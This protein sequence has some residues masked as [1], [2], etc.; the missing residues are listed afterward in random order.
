[1]FIDEKIL[2]RLMMKAYKGNGLYM[3]RYDGWY[4]L[5][6]AFSASWEA[7]IA[8]GCVPKT[9]LGTM[10]ECAGEIPGEGEGWTADKE[11][12]QIEAFDKWSIPKL[13]DLTQTAAHTPVC[14]CSRGG[15]IYRVMQLPNDSVIC[16][17]PD[18][19]AAINPTCVDKDN[20]E[21]MIKGPFYDGRSGLIAYTN[22]ALWHIGG[23][24]PIDTDGIMDIL[25]EQTL[26][27]DEGERN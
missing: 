7:R 21:D 6:A 14:V 11:K 1:M 26:R 16:A 27:Y 10:V 15:M 8:V 5:A 4:H 22:H 23:G 12:N 3:A 18:M 2:K 17:P 24:N 25:S 9:I 13:E 19:L 20:G